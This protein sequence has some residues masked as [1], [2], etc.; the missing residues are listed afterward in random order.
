M[1]ARYNKTHNRT[2]QYN[3]TRVVLAKVNRRL[4]STIIAQ[5]LCNY[6]ILNRS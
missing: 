4:V 3:G 6:R 5:T 1:N 2:S